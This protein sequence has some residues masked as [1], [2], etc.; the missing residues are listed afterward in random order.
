M[1]HYPPILSKRR[2][3]R[4]GARPL[5]QSPPPRARRRPCAGNRDRRRFD[6]PWQPP[7]RPPQHAGPCPGRRHLRRWHLAR[8]RAARRHR[9]RCRLRGRWAAATNRGNLPA[10]KSASK[11]SRCPRK[12][13]SAPD[14][15]PSPPS[16]RRKNTTRFSL[17]RPTIGHSVTRWPGPRA[18]SLRGPSATGGVRTGRR[19][20]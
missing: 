17:N 5:P 1:V 20:S 19:S 9:G 12:L 6:S 8:G 18:G 2:R 10:A 15:D 4:P 11:S 14:T 16:P 3:S 7:R 13:C